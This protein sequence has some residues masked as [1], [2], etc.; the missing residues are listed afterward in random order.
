MN[1][2]VV[3]VDV[4]EDIRNGREPFSKIMTAVAALGADGR[5]LLIAP[6]EPT[7][8]FRVMATRGFRHAAS[9]TASG[10]DRRGPNDDRRDLFLT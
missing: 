7:P 9:P 5:L 4:R 2:D 8:L 10:D 3:T 6:F 1:T